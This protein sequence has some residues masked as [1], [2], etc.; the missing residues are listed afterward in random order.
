MMNTEIV[1][2]ETV[3]AQTILTINKLNRLHCRIL[4]NLSYELLE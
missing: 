2:G 3:E 1:F 4:L